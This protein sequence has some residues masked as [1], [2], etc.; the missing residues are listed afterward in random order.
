MMREIKREENGIVLDFLP[1]GHPLSRDRRPIAQMIGDKYF[2]LLEGIPK[3]GVNLKVGEKVYLGADKREQIHHISGRISS[4]SLT[5]FA[6]QELE[7]R[8]GKIVSERESEFIVFFNKAAGISIRMH[9]FEILPGIGKKHMWRL[10]EERKVKPFESF[11]D[12]QKR[13]TLIPDPKKTIV[14][15]ILIEIDGKDK[16]KIFTT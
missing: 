11:D 5:N 7:E 6:K 14:K 13:V 2:T 4:N 15:R 9:E 10:L 3:I 16:Y 8:I 1:Q 12:I